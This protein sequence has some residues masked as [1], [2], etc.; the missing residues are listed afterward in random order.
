MS[1]WQVL[2]GEAARRRLDAD[3]ELL[4]W[5]ARYAWDVRHVD[6]LVIA[7]APGA[8]IVA[9]AA[10]SGWTIRHAQQAVVE[11]LPPWL[12]ALTA[13]RRLSGRDVTLPAFE[14]TDRSDPAPWRAGNPLERI[15]ERVSLDQ[16]FVERRPELQWA[17]GRLSAGRVEVTAFEVRCQTP[18]AWIE[19]LAYASPAGHELHRVLLARHHATSRE[20]GLRAQRDRLISALHTLGVASTEIATTAL[21]TAPR[22]SQIAGGFG[23]SHV[24][25]RLLDKLLYTLAR[26]PR[27]ERTP[28]ELSFV[29]AQC[30]ERPLRQRERI[31]VER[32]LLKLVGRTSEELAIWARRESRID[33]AAAKA[34]LEARKRRV[35][36]SEI[37][38]QLGITTKTVRQ[39]EQRHGQNAGPPGRKT[40]SAVDDTLA[41]LGRIDLVPEERRKAHAATARRAGRREDRS[42]QRSLPPLLRDNADHRPQ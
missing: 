23:A 39:I 26:P 11:A 12:D 42:R 13:P 38:S 7:L 22:V 28:R 14:I 1:Q 15:P 10:P 2:A 37:A 35:P 33:V 27:L 31:S 17:L 36:V 6:R 24:D 19:P 25:A 40:T 32:D 21:V 20:S 29:V 16:G 30:R 41:D 8:D 3:A 34:I 9:F 18:P 5:K 4:L